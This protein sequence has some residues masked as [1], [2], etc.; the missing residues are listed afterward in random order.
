MFTHVHRTLAQPE[1][2]ARPAV[3]LHRSCIVELG[4][5]LA[6]ARGLNRG[7]GGHTGRRLDVEDA[8]AG[9]LYAAMGLAR[10]KVEPAGLDLDHG[11]ACPGDAEAGGR[12]S[13]P[14]TTA[15]APDS[16]PRLPLRPPSSPSLRP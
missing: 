4:S 13:G 12:G 6:T 10:E 15:G 1:L 3:L 16:R 7:T 14:S 2:A 8:N 5:N 9:R 11:V